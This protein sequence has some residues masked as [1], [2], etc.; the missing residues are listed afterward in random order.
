MR[1]YPQAQSEPYVVKSATNDGTWKT[2]TFRGFPKQLTTIDHSYWRVSVLP[3][4]SG[5]V[6]VLYLCTNLLGK[7][8]LWNGFSWAGEESST[9]T[10]TKHGAYHSAVANGDDVHLV[11][12]KYEATYDILYRKRTYGSGW[13]RETVVQSSPGSSAGPVLSLHLANGDLYC[14][15]TVS[16]SPT[17]ATKVYYKRCS[18]GSWDPSPSILASE[19]TNLTERDRFTG[20]YKDFEGRLGLVYQ[21]GS[22]SPNY[23]VKFALQ[24]PAGR[25]IGSLPRAGGSLPSSAPAARGA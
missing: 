7:G 12:T 15:Y 5:K 2:D 19:T 21:T 17:N 20:F 25:I 24:I 6:Y 14:Y 1:N 18:G 13:G 8:N 23:T 3:L 16:S 4:T 22:S 9:A 10:T 11:F